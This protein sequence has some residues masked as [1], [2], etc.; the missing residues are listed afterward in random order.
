MYDSYFNAKELPPRFDRITLLSAMPGRKPTDHRESQMLMR[1][2]LFFS[3]VM[4]EMYA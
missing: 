2:D 3:V 4:S 1:F